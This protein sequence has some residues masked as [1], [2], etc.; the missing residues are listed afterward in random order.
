M[1]VNN[2]YEAITV[3]MSFNNF[4][5]YFFFSF[6]FYMQFVPA[7]I[8]NKFFQNSFC[9]SAYSVQRFSWSQGV[10]SSLL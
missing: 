7:L 9:L 8:I 3:I 5:Q 6:L 10:K 4:N 2:I 1:K